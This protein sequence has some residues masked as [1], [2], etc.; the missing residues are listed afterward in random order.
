M[1]SKEQIHLSCYTYLSDSKIR[2]AQFY[3]LPKIHKDSKKTSRRPIVSGNGCPTKRISQFIDFF[4]QPCVKNI[5]S[6][7]KDTTDFLQMLQNLGQLLP[8]CLLITLD[9]ASLYTNIPNIEGCQATRLSLDSARSQTDRPL[10]IYLLQ[11]L[12]KA[13][14]CN[15]FDFNVKHYLQVVGTAMG[16]KVA[17]AY[18]NTFM[19]WYEDTYIHLPSTTPSMEEVH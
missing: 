8:D 2:I 17:P 9:V 14:K 13:L 19:G 15:N 10:N 18:A 6:Y 11:L 5:R 16:T 12:D 1:L 4:L 3:I 7:I